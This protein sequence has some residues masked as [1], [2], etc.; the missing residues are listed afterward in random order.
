MIRLPSALL[1]VSVLML[2]IA[3]AS[4]CEAVARSS[5]CDGLFEGRE[6]R[7]P[8]K[9]ARFFGHLRRLDEDGTLCLKDKLADL[10]K[11]S[12]LKQTCSAANDIQWL[13]FGEVWRHDLADVVIYLANPGRGVQMTQPIL[14]WKG[15]AT[16]Y[17]FGREH[18]FV[19]VFAERKRDMVASL[20]TR[21]QQPGN[22]FSGLL[23]LISL[24]APETKSDP[25]K[26]VEA[27]IEWTSLNADPA[28]KMYLGW[29]R[30]PVKRDSLNHLTVSFKDGPGAGD[31]FTAV[32]VHF[33]N[34]D[35]SR[36]G[37][38]VGLAATLNTEGTGFNEGAETT[39]FGG[40]ALGKLY[41]IRPRL[42]ID[43]GRLFTR[44][45]PSLALTVGTNVVGG[46]TF[47]EFVVGLSLSHLF[48][49]A[50]LFVGANRT[51]TL[52]VTTDGPESA[53]VFESKWR[54]ILGAE[55]SF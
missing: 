53:M 48:G 24:S 41:L 16:P 40:Y 4:P 21:F 10:Q 13:L 32:S 46:D 22:P 25:E 52:R 42:K 18:I 9:T 35:G 34:A 11:C 43:P 33:T 36:A 15:R 20:L 55:Y 44:S 7:D 14:T 37:F 19:L 2:S 30:L 50:G 26:P 47:D 17:L 38:G 8:T 39:H 29:A 3:V 27:A 1:L 31:Q 5:P 6:T 28:P 23:Q 45:R 12:N 51:P 49:K 54:P